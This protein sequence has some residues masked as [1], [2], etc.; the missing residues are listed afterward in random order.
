M[1]RDDARGQ[2]L[3]WKIVEMAS[4]SNPT[5]NTDPPCS[6]TTRRPWEGKNQQNRSVWEIYREW[7]EIIQLWSCLYVCNIAAW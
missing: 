6:F 7:N 2:E 3:A 5:T 1:A 4:L